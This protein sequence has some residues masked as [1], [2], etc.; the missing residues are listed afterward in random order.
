M[1]AIDQVVGSFAGAGSTTSKIVVAEVTLPGGTVTRN[2]D[3]VVVQAVAFDTYNDG[4]SIET[5]AGDVLA[6]GIGIPTDDVQEVE[7]IRTGPSGAFALNPDLPNASVVLDWNE[8]QTF[9]V[10]A[11]A[12][13]TVRLARIA[14][15]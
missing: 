8:D 5:S 4:F 10:R 9:R 15:D 11:A 1:K 6:I 7:L 14:S 12:G 13:V 2:G 3:S